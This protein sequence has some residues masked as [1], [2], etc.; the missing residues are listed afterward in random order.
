MYFTAGHY[1]LSR[2]PAS[3]K[4]SD[5]VSLVVVELDA[6]RAMLDA[7]GETTTAPRRVRGRRLVGGDGSALAAAG[8][9]VH[10][11]ERPGHGR[12]PDRDCA[13]T[14]E[15][16]A[17]DTVAYLRAVLSGPVDLVGWSDGA[18]VALLIARD[19]PQLVSRLVLIGSTSATQDGCG[20]PRS[21]LPALGRGVAHLRA[22]HLRSSPD[23]AE[24]FDAVHARTM[25]IDSGPSLGLSTFA[26]ISTPTLVLQGDRDVVTVEHGAA[27]ARA[28]ADGRLAV[29]PGGHS[30]PTE[31]P[32]VVTAVLRWFLGRYE[33]P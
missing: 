21:S 2:R 11:P 15:S 10:V 22:A 23:G 7:A 4:A 26:T 28:L 14:H 13:V 30:P 20:A 12:T 9:T 17:A 33:P 6:F 19:A 1:D 18:V 29:L 27:V 3:W 5:P 25:N 32:A 8:R 16:M 31:H 24:R